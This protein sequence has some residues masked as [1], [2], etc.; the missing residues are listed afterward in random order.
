MSHYPKIFLLI[1]VPVIGE[2]G[3]KTESE[4]QVICEEYSIKKRTYDQIEIVLDAWDGEDLFVLKTLYFLTARLKEK[5]EEKGFKGLEF[6]KVITSKGDYFKFGKE[7]Y[8][9]ELPEVY[10]IIFNS[11]ADGPDIWWKRKAFCEECK[12][13]KWILAEEGITSSIG[14]SLTGT[15]KDVANPAPRWVY[16]ST[17][18]G[19]DIFKLQDPVSIPF[20]TEYFLKLLEREH[21]KGFF[22]RKTEWIDQ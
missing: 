13:W 8:Q 17:W 4:L 18:D 16:K 21:V 5:I 19:S 15:G 14:P 9:K 11:E 22:T 2:L 12:C 1:E 10:Q 6:K 7:A 20:I 3:E